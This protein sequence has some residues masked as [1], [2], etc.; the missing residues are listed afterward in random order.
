MTGSP[1]KV[2]TSRELCR[3]GRYELRADE[4]AWPDGTTATYGVFRQPEAA[5]IVPVSERGTTFLWAAHLGQRREAIG[6]E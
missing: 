4:V 1:F 2:L 3:H 5:L 6:L